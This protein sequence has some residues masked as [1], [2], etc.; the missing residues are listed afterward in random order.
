VRKI[1]VIASASG[2]GKT[3][4]GR[5]LAHRIGAQFIELDELVHGPNWS[6]T[7]DDELRLLLEP[8]LAEDAWVIDGGYALRTHLSRR[9]RYPIE[10]APFPVVRLRTRGEVERFV[11]GVGAP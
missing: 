2:N 7:P 8:V 5:E 6:E 11:N 10:L 9:R 3:T 1:S 4:V